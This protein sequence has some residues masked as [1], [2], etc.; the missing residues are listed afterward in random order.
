[1]NLVNQ[2]WSIFLLMS[3]H[4][5]S[6]KG[7][8]INQLKAMISWDGLG[9]PKPFGTATFFGIATTGVVILPTQTMH[10]YFRETPQTY[11]RCLLFDYPQS[12]VYNLM[13][14]L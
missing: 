5:F 4:F 10:G 1:M 3:Q 8:A 12:R 14:H 7:R 11:N 2:V 9:C 6:T 13:T